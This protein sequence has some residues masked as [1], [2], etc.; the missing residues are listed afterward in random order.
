[1]SI[2]DYSKYFDKNT[3]PSNHAPFFPKNIFAIIAGSTGCEKTNL[4][5]NFLFEEGYLDYGQVYFYS[6]TLHQEGYKMAMRF[7]NEMYEKTK[8]YIQI[9]YFLDINDEDD[10][11][12][13]K[14][15]AK[16]KK[17]SKKKGK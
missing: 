8:K 4:L 17:K 7:Y 2:K 9:A 12:D 6:S 16:G 10:D 1:M 13:D 15:K 3:S 11:D 14:T 5:F